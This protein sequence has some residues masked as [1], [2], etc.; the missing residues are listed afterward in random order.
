MHHTRYTLKGGGLETIYE[1]ANDIAFIIIR[2]GLSQKQ[3]MFTCCIYLNKSPLHKYQHQQQYHRV[4]CESTT[5]QSV[6]ILI[7]DYIY[8]QPIQTDSSKP[9]N[10]ATVTLF[11]RLLI[12][13]YLI[14]CMYTICGNT[15]HSCISTHVTNYIYPY[16]PPHHRLSIYHPPYQIDYNDAV[17]SSYCNSPST[18][19]GVKISIVVDTLDNHSSGEW[20]VILRIWR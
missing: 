5:S 15:S 14:I 8:N 6:F 12:T 3:W 4:S 19:L 9:L 1:R 2:P 20:K 16:P 7:F 18:V 11:H 13:F 17:N 10:A